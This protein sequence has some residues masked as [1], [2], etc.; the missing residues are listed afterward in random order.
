M[1]GPPRPQRCNCGHWFP[2]QHSAMACHVCSCP[3]WHTSAIIHH[4]CTRDCTH[5]IA[6]DVM[7]NTATNHD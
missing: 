2:V 4:T 6:A 7:T 1:Y 3:F 5:T